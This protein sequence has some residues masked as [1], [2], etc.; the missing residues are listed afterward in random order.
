M[1]IDVAAAHLWIKPSV[2]PI[3]LSKVWLKTTTSG[4]AKEH[5]KKN[6]KRKA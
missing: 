4:E 6:L 5:L 3:N 1:T 2:K